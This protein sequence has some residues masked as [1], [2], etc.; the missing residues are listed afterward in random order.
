[1][2][3]QS[4]SVIIV[5]LMGALF[6]IP[7]VTYSF[8]T[9]KDV[10]KQA[11][12]EF[13]AT[14]LIVKL[15]PEVDKKIILGQIKGTITT[16]LAQLDS[17]NL[18]FK[19]K[20]QEKLFKEFKET[21]LK[22]D[23]FSSVY[24]LEVPEGTDLEKMKKEYEGRSE[25]EYAE[26]DYKLE[27]FEVPNDPLFPNQWYLNNAGQGYLGINR[28]PG[29]YNDT[30]V[31]KYGTVDA[32][33][34]ALE[35]WE[36]DDETTIPLVGII[37]T[38]LDLDHEDLADHIWTNPGEIPN[39][40]IDDDHNGFVDD[41]YGWD[42]SGNETDTIQE[43]NDPT[44]YY[45]HGT[46]CAGIV[47][48]VRDNGRGVSGINTP[49]KIMA[50]KF[51]PNAF[52]SLGAKSIIYAADMGCD[53]INMS[54][55]G[56]YP[57]MV[58]EDALDY[59][60]GK[61]VLPIAASGN[62]GGED[63]FYPASLPQ[64]FTVGAS[65]SDDEVTYFSTYGNYIE[66]VAPG[67]D[68]LSL[69]ADTTD[70][71]AEGGASGNEPLVHIV[72]DHYYLADG[73]SM[74]SPCVVGVA[75]H[76]LAASPGI[77]NERVKEIIQ[78]SADDFPP[79][80]W[81]IYSGYGRVNLNSALQLLSGRLAKIDYPYENALVSGNVAILGTASGD[82]FQNYVLEYG[83]GHSPQYWTQIAS[84]NVPV[85]KDTLG[86]WNSSGLVGRFTLRLTVG[87]QNQ[88][89]VHVIANNGINVKITSPSDGDTVKGDVEVYGNTVVPDFSH[90]TLEYGYGA[91]P[92]YWYTITT[93]TRMVADGIL[94]NWMLSPLHGG[95]Y[96][97]RLTVNSDGGQIHADTVV[98]FVKSIV[99]EGWSQELTACGSLSPAVGD[100]DGDGYD[101]VVVGV[102]GGQGAGLAGGIEVFTREGEREV[103]WPKD[104]YKNMMS[105]P[106]LGDLDGDSINDI[107]ICSEQG[108]V[109]AYLSG[110]PNWV[111]KVYTGG[112]ALWSL[113]TPVIADLE[114]DGYL[115]VLIVNDSGTVYAWRHDGE[116]VIPDSDGVFAQ[117]GVL[118]CALG[119]PCLTVADLDID[120]ENEVIAGVVGGIYI[121]DIQGNLLGH[122]PDEFTCVCGIAIANID[123]NEDLEI[124]AFGM[125]TSYST[126]S[127]YKKDG[128]QRANYPIILEDLAEGLWFGN[129]PAIGD[130]DGDGILEIV[131][132]I[133]T[134][135]EARIYVWHQDGTPL[136]SLGPGGLLVSMKSPNAEK[137]R[138]ALSILGNNIA[139]IVAK[140]KSMSQ[141]E[142]T[143]LFSTFE[144]PVFASVPETFGSPVLA[145]VS[146]DGNVDIIARAGYCLGTGYERVF[147][148]DYQGNLVPGFPLYASDERSPYTFY[149]YT[150]VLADMDKDG[151][152]N[153][154]L[155]TNRNNYAPAKLISWE[156]DTDYNASRMPWPKYMH[157][158][159]NSGIHGFQ[160][161][162]GEIPNI[163]PPNFHA[164]SWTDSSITLSWSPRTPWLSV[165]YNIYRST[166]SGEPGEKINTNLIPQAEGQY[167]DLGLPLG[168]TYY[169]AM[170]NVDTS[171]QESARSNEL[172]VSVGQ[173]TAPTGLAAQVVGHIV[174]LHWNPN[175]VGE[176][177]TKYRI[178]SKP[179]NQTDYQLIDSVART[180]YVDD[181]PKLMEIYSYQITAVNH[182][183]L[184]SYPSQSIEVDIR[185]Q[186]FDRTDYNVGERVY[187]VFCAD[188]DN[189]NDLDLAVANCFSDS[190]FILM[191]NGQGGFQ[192]RVGYGVGGSPVSVFCADLDKDND[193]DLT[194]A[195][196]YSDNVSILMNNGQGGFQNRVDYGVGDGP[197]SVFCADLDNDNDL[198]LAVAN[199]YSDTVSILF[200][201][202]YGG[203]QDKVDY[204]VGDCPASVFCAD[205]DNDNDLDLAV[206]N[207]YSDNVSILF[208]NGY[209]GL[210]DKVDYG[211]GNCPAS[212]FCADLDKDN[213]LDLAVANAHSHN[214]SILMNN[215]DGTLQSAVNYGARSTS[216]AVFCVDLNADN[217]LDLAVANSGNDN[218]SILMNNGDGTFADA[219]NYG[220][221]RYPVSV[222][223]ADLNNDGDLDLAVA[224]SGS[225]TVSIL[226]NN[227]VFAD[228][229]PGDVNRD[230]EVNVADVVF[231]INY[232]F[233]GG[234]SPAIIEA[235][236]VNGDCS[237]NIVDVVYLVN[238]LFIGGPQP[239]PGCASP[240]NYL[241][242][243]AKVKGGLVIDATYQN[244]ITT[245]SVRSP[246]ELLGVQLQLE[247]PNK[248]TPVNLLKDKLDLV[249]GFREDTLKIGLLDLDGG[250]AIP[251]GKH[252]LIQLEG[253]C[254]VLSALVC[255][256][257]FTAWSASINNGIEE[258]NVPKTYALS[259]NYPNPFNPE[260]V[261]E[262][263]LPKESQVKVVIYNI[264]GQRVRTLVDQKELAGY[265]RVV[266]DGKDN[267]KQAV[268]S[269]TY[270]Y[271]IEA[272]AEG[273]RFTRTKKMV[274]LK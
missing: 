202:G 61:G 253:R 53:V 272:K 265:K 143:A 174:A 257:S 118:S 218:V 205:L 60:I 262:Y 131:I 178:Y 124:I 16:G 266:W 241:G 251:P 149:P 256:K 93:S 78:E 132:T 38:G 80:G 200:N 123:E 10:T 222:F 254:Q 62:S 146:G 236:D 225:G 169:Y 219:V 65:N 88:A 153:M 269:G 188:L 99:S 231:L 226:M 111:R 175:P 40:G 179:P 44:D 177:V 228:Y 102:G 45:G 259:Q 96:S 192:N 85:S 261:I 43:D 104:T 185:T 245:I 156:F 263:S 110:S 167:Q 152:L 2:K 130:L 248:S 77:S 224:N 165:G 207:G 145:D 196:E 52:S 160:P 9:G 271:R 267:R 122:Y 127:A 27:L 63:Y 198:D 247:S 212:I 23:R 193:L 126:L 113:A 29:D 157:D 41:F 155:V 197:V 270:F 159:Y 11:K 220:V 30:Q 237:V 82:S 67:E 242:K 35:A 139:E 58:I 109:H 216:V 107:V 223:C 83:E 166:V 76:I 14:R 42:F 8:Y 274:L 121:W 229:M 233:Q 47:A 154:V 74:A 221:G 114:N 84:S 7:P 211:V 232:L 163:P 151:K 217:D 133:W 125:D 108:G 46:H 187:S 234:P 227:L 128:T 37:D 268:S 92:T 134:L 173:P 95:N 19:V 103:G 184:E 75:A 135:G 17:L 215:G 213:D 22:L 214:V 181:S 260:T 59:A 141:E 70:M 148:W 235:G 250:N 162:A 129:H 170:T 180:S 210:Q 86:I 5:L 249:Y 26:L 94:G 81:D 164:K 66:V 246:V 69:R 54:W 150:P 71:Y 144:D 57:S 264:L 1:M 206:A 182:I 98:V 240:G 18:K 105:S 183:G 208:N 199:G 101:E 68:I 21:A 112:H 24:I 87:S 194:V 168:Q 89:L 138:E 120:G 191:N 142:L 64:V 230:D 39:N 140:V 6:F 147:A 172:E 239:V 20:K 176:N 3:K 252:P 136:G 15:K 51:F 255:D 195:N 33:I 273:E 34:D 28:I 158:K 73:T 50:I 119:F 244:G 25:V 238:Y 90:Y 137:K 106:A 100:I 117:T 116:S 189:D 97:I 31:I 79:L 258:T 13:S 55:G 161:E 48:A 204:S 12:P 36:R 32:D 49:C 203:F 72:N 243:P 186:L 171:N 56:P 190:V 91:S 115:E 201:N 4:L 209:G